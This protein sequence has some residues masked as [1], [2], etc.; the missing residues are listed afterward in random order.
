MKILTLGLVVCFSCVI[1]L[2]V[3]S[4]GSEPSPP[5]E[6]ARMFYM[7]L[8]A[9]GNVQ[10]VREHSALKILS[11]AVKE[12]GSVE[13]WVRTVHTER[14]DDGFNLTGIEILEEDIEDNQAELRLKL[15]DAEGDTEEEDAYLVKE[16]G[17]W[18]VTTE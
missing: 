3:S 11:L 14:F 6:V 16:N 5:A 8:Y 12:Y 9:T 17:K 2:L 13:N 10:V 1:V 7:A 15:C 4:C 18:K